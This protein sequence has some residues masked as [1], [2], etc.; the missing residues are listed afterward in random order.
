MGS[1]TISWELDKGAVRQ[2]ISHPEAKEIVLKAE[3]NA[4]DFEENRSQRVEEFKRVRFYTLEEFQTALNFFELEYPKLRK[5]P[6]Q[7]LSQSRMY[8]S[9][10]K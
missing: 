8:V 7:Q 1:K 10:F 5:Y 2:L 4:Y 3:Y 9:E 6:E